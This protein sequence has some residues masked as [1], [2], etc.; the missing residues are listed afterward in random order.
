MPTKLQK[1]FPMLRNRDE[2]LKEIDANVKLTEKFY[3][4]KEEQRQEFLDIF[5]ENVD[6]NGIKN[7]LDA[8][9]TF[10]GM[11][12]PEKIIELIDRYP[13]FSAMYEHVYYICRNVEDIMGIFSEELKIMDRNT[14]K[15]MVDEM[16]EMIDEKDRQ[17]EEKAQEIE[18]NKQCM[19]EKDLKI[20]ELEK[21]LAKYR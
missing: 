8:W 12:E 2:I 21:E 18:E 19:K 13:E 16:Q 20:E 7:K 15:Y 1:Y 9:L 6:N 17:L 14:V 11:D 3:S 10:L 4:W 5:R